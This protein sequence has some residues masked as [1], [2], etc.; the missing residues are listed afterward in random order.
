MSDLG[1]LADDLSVTRRNR[2]DNQLAKVFGHEET[3]AGRALRERCLKRLADAIKRLRHDQETTMGAALEAAGH[4][5]GGRRGALCAV[6]KRVN[7]ER[8]AEAILSGAIRVI[9]LR[10]VPLDGQDD[11][12]TT[13]RVSFEHIG[14]NLRLACRSARLLRK[15]GTGYLNSQWGDD[16]IHTAGG[17]GVDVLLD[18]LPDMFELVQFPVVGGEDYEYD[19]YL[20]LTARGDKILGELLRSSVRNDPYHVPA[21]KPPREWTDVVRCGEHG[22]RQTLIRCRLD[23]P[24]MKAARKALKSER[25]DWLDALHKLESVGYRLNEPMYRY[26]CRAYA[27]TT[28]DKPLGLDFLWVEEPIYCRKWNPE[29]LRWD[30]RKERWT[31]GAWDPHGAVCIPYPASV[32]SAATIS[33]PYLN[34][35]RESR[36]ETTV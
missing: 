8:V 14:H 16:L 26:V 29:K 25:R 6:L 1:D 36:L 30:K 23:S 33:A 18:A 9:G 21:L 11:H 12:D 27:Q 13:I 7:S 19:N 2:R 15:A 10:S 34:L 35:P 4:P 3:P 24:I 5:H 31:K 20:Q 28:S 17:W 32:L 22:E